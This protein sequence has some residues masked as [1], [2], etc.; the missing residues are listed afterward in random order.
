[1]E[2]FDSR[3][4]SSDIDFK[5][6]EEIEVGEIIA[7]FD[8]SGRDRSWRDYRQIRYFWPN[9]AD[10]YIRIYELARTPNIEYGTSNKGQTVPPSNRES[11][12]LKHSVVFRSC[13]F[14]NTTDVVFP[15][16]KS[17]LSTGELSHPSQKTGVV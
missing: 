13:Y 4:H 8:I 16:G 3:M 6:H 12:S 2:G 9:S 14:E 15:R 11:H 10:L 1:M 5:V 7:K 17:Y